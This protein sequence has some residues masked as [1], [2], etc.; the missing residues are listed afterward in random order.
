MSYRLRGGGVEGFETRRFEWRVR[1]PSPPGRL[2]WAGGSC[3]ECGGKPFAW[4]VC[5]V[6]LCGWALLACLVLWR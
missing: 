3:L 2:E 5:S 1:V 6:F 4:Q